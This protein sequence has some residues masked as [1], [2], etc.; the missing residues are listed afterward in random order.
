MMDPTEWPSSPFSG[1][2][3][4]VARTSGPE[5]YHPLAFWPFKGKEPWHPRS[6]FGDMPKTHSALPLFQE[7]L[8]LVR[9]AHEYDGHRDCTPALL[10]PSSPPRVYSDQSSSCL[11]V[12]LMKKGLEREAGF[13]L[14]HLPEGSTSAAPGRIPVGQ[15]E[16]RRG[17]LLGQ[18]PGICKSS[19]TNKQTPRR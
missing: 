3:L 18:H 7:P 13:L 19:K 14:L 10:W 1:K 11:A 9:P 16:K 12:T 6:L 4:R 2:G 15:R 17:L 8:H 5:G